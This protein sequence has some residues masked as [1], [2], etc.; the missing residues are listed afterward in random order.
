MNA[1]ASHT[2]T[3][4]LA[5][6]AHSA[7]LQVQQNRLTELPSFTKNILLELI[8]ADNNQLQRLPDL[9]ANVALTAMYI[10]LNRLTE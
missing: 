2:H 5:R 10:H 3:R 6:S 8:V 7:K 9:K 4:F 1:F